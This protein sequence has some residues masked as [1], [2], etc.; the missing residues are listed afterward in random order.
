M[1]QCSRVSLQVCLKSVKITGCDTLGGRTQLYALCMKMILQPL[2]DY[3][4]GKEEECKG[5]KG[6]SV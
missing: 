6:L 4:T 2:E 3:I 5:A 1:K